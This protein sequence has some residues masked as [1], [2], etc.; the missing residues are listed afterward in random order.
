MHLRIGTRTSK[1]ALI[2]TEILISELKLKCEFTY[3]VVPIITTGDKVTSVPLYDI[4]GKALFIKELEEALIENKID[5]AV[6]SLKDVPGILSDKFIISAML[7]R[8]T[9]NDCFISR[10]YKSIAELPKG[11]I[12][13]TSSP[14]RA[15]IAKMINPSIKT[16]PIRGNVATRLKLIES[17]DCDAIILAEVGLR[18][19]NLWNNDIC[20]VISTDE[21][22]PAVGQGV[23]A[24][25]NL[26]S[27]NDLSNLLSKI[28]DQRT[29][30]ELSVERAFLFELDANCS[31]P[32]A[33]Y[34][35]QL[36]NDEFSGSFLISSDDYEK[37]VTENIKFSKDQIN[38]VGIDIAKKMKKKLLDN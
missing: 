17:G 18:R 34:V 25:E 2:Q 31:T 11:S 14:R 1:L 4:G 36:S 38:H 19:L 37:V 27:R 22:V 21:M 32:V 29:L 13:G 23:I 16:K 9:A 30:L 28:S 26:S 12:L 5:I 7:E 33:G 6:H 20:H 3:E 35:K 24:I 10:K 15:L 8:S